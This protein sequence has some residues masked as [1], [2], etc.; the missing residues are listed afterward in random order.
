M[1]PV[2]TSG[3]VSAAEQRA[4]GDHTARN[5]WVLVTF[6][7]LTNLADGITKVALSIMATSLTSSP[8]LVSGVLLT[9][10]LPW[11]LVAL[12]VG[13]LVDR[14]DRR[15]LL[16]LANGLRM[17][18]VLGLLVAVAAGHLSLPMLYGG[19]LV[20]GVAEVV[21]LTSAAA[22]TPD[23]VAPA[24]RER[25]STWVSAAETLCNEFAG[26]FLG[27]LLV[28]VGAALALGA[29]AGA[30]TVAIAVL[31][32]PVGRFRIER[33]A[34][35]PKQSMR[36]QAAEGVRFLWH[37]PLLRAQA[38]TVTVLIT[39][40]SAWLALM[41]LV[42]VKTMGLSAGQYG[43]LVGA[44]GIG[45]LAGTLSVPAATANVWAVGAAAFLGGA[46]GGLWTVNA[47]TIGQ[48]L[49]GPQ[50]MG[51]YSAANRLFS[52]GSIPLGAAVAGTLA[53]SLGTRATFAVFATTA[54][55][56]VIPFL[57]AF[58]P[59]ALADHETG[60]HDVAEP[61]LASS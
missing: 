7:A 38:L 1:E 25:A 48:S 12:P 39:C 52:W 11:L 57:H 14:A 42:A 59:A 28:A 2:L 18:V 30:Y 61:T 37:Q 51:R 47:R 53:Q 26:P 17:T 43:A 44:L 6:T 46:G 35:T 21:A 23:A 58:T 15:R 16:R 49:V 5:T 31:S 60:L 4:V 50:M 40:W 56:A 20:L 41:P 19:G 10:T 13:V 22:I 3:A 36:G 27:G 54:A 29:T 9:L 45:G 32:L 8:A 34:D 55:A 33:A 24:G